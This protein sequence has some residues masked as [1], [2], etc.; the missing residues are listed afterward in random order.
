MCI[1]D[2]FKFVAL[3]GI[4]VI[5]IVVAITGFS[6]DGSASEEWKSGWF[7]HT[8]VD[9]SGWA[10]ALYAGLWAFDG[11]DNVSYPRL[12]MDQFIY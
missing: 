7:Q 2:S 10:V 1:R 11:W 6:S 3:I 5:G 8:N 4:T 9:I 12:A